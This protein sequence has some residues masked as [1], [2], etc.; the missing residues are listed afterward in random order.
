MI[1]SQAHYSSR[2][3]F[4][5]DYSGNLPA[6]P[7]QTN[8][9][10]RGFD[11]NPRRPVHSAITNLLQHNAPEELQIS[12]ASTG[13]YTLQ[14][15]SAKEAAEKLHPHHNIPFS[16]EE[17]SH[18]EIENLKTEVLQVNLPSIV[19]PLEDPVTNNVESRNTVV[20]ENKDQPDRGRQNVPPGKQQSDLTMVGRSGENLPFPWPQEK[21]PVERCISTDFYDA[22]L[23]CSQKKCPVEMSY[24]DIKSYRG[25][26]ELGKG[27]FGVVYEGTCTKSK[28]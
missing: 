8:P 12:Q 2:N 1:T 13:G 24:E 3:P 14:Q 4:F 5:P 17:K 10:L 23:Y 15:D 26:K 21:V 28:I 19:K 7:T 6:N 9:F 22:G 11:E 16:Q 20:P 27:G 18:L 25:A